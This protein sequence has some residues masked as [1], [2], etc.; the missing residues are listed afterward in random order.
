[1]HIGVLRGLMAGE[2]VAVVEIPPAPA[3]HAFTVCLTHDIDHPVLGN[4]GLDHTG[5]GFL[6]R[7]TAGSVARLLRG[8]MTFGELLRNWWAACSMN[9]LL[10]LCSSRSASLVRRSSSL[11][12]AS[13]RSAVTNSSSRR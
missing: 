2:G 8:R 11:R 7:A 10:R 12:C 9:W 4:H 5:L 1:M 6:Y 3:G 13:D